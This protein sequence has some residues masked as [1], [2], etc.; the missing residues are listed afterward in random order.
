VRIAA[1]KALASFSRAE[2]LPLLCELINDQNSDVRVL[3][4][5]EIGSSVVP[6]WRAS[7]D[8]AD[9]RQCSRLTI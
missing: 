8:P 9:R 4:V 6:Y 2:D 5:A 7:A 3:A 1:M